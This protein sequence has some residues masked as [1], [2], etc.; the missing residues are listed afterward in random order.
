MTSRRSRAEIISL[1]KV[2]MPW[3]EVRSDLLPADERGTYEHRRRALDKY[4]S[5]E[6]L[7][8]IKNA[9][10]VGGNYLRKI[11]ARCLLV[12][13]DGRVHGYRAL[14]PNFSI[15][16][17]TRKKTFSVSVGAKGS[18]F[19]GV[20]NA[21]FERYPGL[22][23]SLDAFILK[24]KTYKGVSETDRFCNRSKDVHYEF[25]QLLKGKDHPLHEWPY[26]HK[27]R[28]SRTISQYVR[29][30]RDKNFETTVRLVGNKGAVAHLA[31]N[32]GP[33]PAIR[34]RGL[35]DGWE[36]DS[37]K[38]DAAFVLGLLNSAGLISYLELKCLHIIVAVESYIGGAMWYRVV[39]G[40]DVTSEDIVALIREAMGRK[41]PRP[42]EY[43]PNLSVK[44]GGGFPAEMF[45]ELNQSPPSLI[46]LDNALAHLSVKVSSEL[47]KQIGCTF[48]YGPPGHF[49]RRPNI[50]KFFDQ[51]SNE[52]GKRMRSSTGS[53]PDGGGD[54]NPGASAKKYMIESR[55]LEQLA[56]VLLANLNVEP[57]EGI[58]FLT[59]KEAMAQ[60]ITDGDNHFLPR[61]FPLDKRDAIGTGLVREARVVRGSI[62]SGTRPYI[63]FE[64]A[65]YSSPRLRDATSL[66]GQEI[67][68]E[69]NE[70]DITVIYA[71]LNTGESLGPLT[72]QGAWAETPHSRKTRKKINSLQH[73]KIISFIEGQNPV[74][75]YNQYLEDQ[76]NANDAAGKK[77]RKV[78]SEIDR[79]RTEVVR[80]KK[81]PES[82]GEIESPPAPV[83]VAEPTPVRE[84]VLPTQEIDLFGLIRKLK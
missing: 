45:P 31:V 67:L 50:E 68:L 10:G 82:P 66:F 52:L 37:Q 54:K 6:S 30:M 18:G 80:S 7:R 22:Q 48:E 43:V 29:D 8:D 9:T 79:L 12:A 32:A 75:V 16:K 38:V 3:D 23:T 5:G 21:I 41:L 33:S 78:A 44:D 14:I 11:I 46:Q 42:V 24:K 69:I 77:A 39:Y 34:L 19:S 84:W 27:N 65:R 36:I 56:Y 73:L 83:V 81:P 2:S 57:N 53:G 26:T 1:I 61:S 40:D 64:R 72:V 17:Y 60:L 59:P 20:L 47:R 35:N 63:N 49:E 62:E 74:R 4:L 76:H 28:G 71:F 55:V 25:I 70:S 15:K 13:S 58:G 51:F